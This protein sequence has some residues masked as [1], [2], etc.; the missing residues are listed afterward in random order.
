MTTRCR[1]YKGTPEGSVLASILEY[2]AVER[3]WAVRM[4]SGALPITGK[5]GKIRP[6]RFGTPGMGDILA[7]P[8]VEC[9]NGACQRYK[10]PVVL[11]IE[12]KAADGRQSEAQ[13]SFASQARAAGHEY[14]VA[15]SIED[16]REYLKTHNLTGSRP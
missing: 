6:M 11:W 14:L 7:T 3:I 15:R 16:V 8:M 2:L 1:A 13:K 9:E 4:Q 10:M 12:C 5:G